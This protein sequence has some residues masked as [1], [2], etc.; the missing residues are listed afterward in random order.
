MIRSG[1]CNMWNVCN[2]GLKSALHGMSQSN[3]DLVILQET[4][5]TGSVYMRSLAGFIVVATDSPSLYCGGV[6]L[7]YN[8]S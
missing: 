7:F 2:A 4:N 1:S 8:D 6:M 3:M 5:I